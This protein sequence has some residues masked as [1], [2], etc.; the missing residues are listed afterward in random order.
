MTWFDDT[1]QARFRTRSLNQTRGAHLGHLPLNRKLFQFLDRLRLM[2]FGRVRVPQH[3]LDLA[4]TEQGRERHQIDAGLD[5]AGR[6]GVLQIVDP[7]AFDARE[8]LHLFTSPPSSP[9]S[10]RRASVLASFSP[11]FQVKRPGFAKPFP[12]GFL[13][14]PRLESARLLATP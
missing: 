12:L 1:Y 2:L 3:H 9:S 4:V 11:L 5:G 8:L 10:R 7:E 13:L 6:E 14:A